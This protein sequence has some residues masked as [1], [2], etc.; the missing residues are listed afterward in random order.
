MMIA[1]TVMHVIGVMSLTAAIII[2]FIINVAARK[3]RS[4]AEKKLPIR[5]LL[6]R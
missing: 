2:L 6:K 1:Y 4:E 3:F 5:D